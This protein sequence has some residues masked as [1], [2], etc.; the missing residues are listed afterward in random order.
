MQWQI[1]I[2][3]ERGRQV[4]REDEAGSSFRPATPV[5]RHTGHPFIAAWRSDTS[6]SGVSSIHDQF[7]APSEPLYFGSIPL[8]DNCSLRDGA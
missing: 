6:I 4:V 1:W 3:M 8:S 7:A 2:E 5:P